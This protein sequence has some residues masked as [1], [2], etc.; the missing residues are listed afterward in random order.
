MGSRC[1]IPWLQHAFPIGWSQLAKAIAN[2]TLIERLLQRDKTLLEGYVPQGAGS[3]EAGIDTNSASALRRELDDMDIENPIT[4]YLI[5][6]AIQQSQFTEAVPWVLDNLLSQSSNSG[7][8]ADPEARLFMRAELPIEMMTFVADSARS[9]FSL[10]A[11]IDSLISL[12][13]NDEV[14]AACRRAVLVLGDTDFASWVSFANEADFQLNPVV[15]LFCSHQAR[16]VAPF[17]ERPSCMREVTERTLE[18]VPPDFAAGLERKPRGTAGSDDESEDEEFLV[19]IAEVANRRSKDPE[20]FRVW[21]PSNL[22]LGAKPEDVLDGSADIR[23]FV[24]DRF[25]PEE[26]GSWFT[27]SCDNCW[28]RIKSIRYAVR[29]PLEAGGW[30]G[31]YCSWEC[32]RLACEDYELPSYEMTLYYEKQCAEFGIYDHLFAPRGSMLRGNGD[33]DEYTVPVE[34]PVLP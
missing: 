3:G 4:L 25:T 23:M 34:R 26:Q 1:V 19:Q 21:G 31:Q 24:D 7:S 11:V 6:S 16:R 9:R 18:E 22:L 17:A 15:W 33:P 8:Y 12:D 29:K 27:G 14:Y 2:M 10:A 5:L 13:S 30:R 20:L 28:M 32:C